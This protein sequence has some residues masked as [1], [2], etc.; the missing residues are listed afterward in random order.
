MAA[1]KPFA[2]DAFKG[3]A[4]TDT[5]NWT[6]FTVMNYKPKT[7]T[8]DDVEVAITH[9]G[10]C[11]SD[12]HTITAGWGAITPP[13][14]VGHEIV[15]IATRVGKNVTEIKLGDRVGVGAQIASCFTCKACKNHNENYC[16]NMIDTYG[17]EYPDGT[18][19]MGG[20]SLA[21]RA[22]KLFAFHIPD[23]LASV[24]AASMLCAGLTVYSPLVRNG[25]GPGKKVGVA[26]IGGLGHY[27]IM[28]AHA[29]GAEVTAFSH[30]PN[31]K[32][33]VLKMGAD[34]FVISSEKDFEKP[35]QREFDIIICALNVSEGFPIG[36]YLTM[37]DVAG[38]FVMVG[39]PEG[40]LPALTA[41][42]LLPNGC[43]IAGSH[44]GNH[45]EMIQ[46][47]QLAADK[48]LK[49]WVE[50]MPMKDCGKAV[51]AVKDGKVRYRVVLEQDLSL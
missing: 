4:V 45:E 42:N 6:D 50:T 39:L 37:L 34:K 2:E 1:I 25:C 17:S 18:K 12:V 48:G 5:A 14:V 13:L 36:Q 43:R 16:P 30:S 49:P 40:H 27:A 26:G 10:V 24:D 9:C 21:I 28:F 8:E 7:F 51:Q 29:L 33:D 11:G 41:F 23:G 47:L 3:Y 38:I 19:T 15:G 20:Y 44:L 31:K 46:M 32:D 22:N 35:F